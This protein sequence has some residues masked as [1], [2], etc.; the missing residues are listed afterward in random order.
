MNESEI[1]S[2]FLSYGCGP[3]VYCKRVWHRQNRLR[4]GRRQARLC[5]PEAAGGGCSTSLRAGVKLALRCS[6]EGGGG[7][8]G[9]VIWADGTS[10][11]R[12][13]D[14]CRL[15]VSPSLKSSGPTPDTIVVLL[16]HT[17]S[18]LFLEA[19]EEE[20][21]RAGQQDASG[22]RTHSGGRDEDATLFCGERCVDPEWDK[23]HVSLVYPLKTGFEL[24]GTRSF[25]DEMWDQT[26]N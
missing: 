11:L 25:A 12:S 14:E 23:P 9:S 10:S 17:A 22:L 15:S 26:L 19:D 3:T 4:D 21:A 18:S 1:Y 2:C 16:S 5:V 24:V 8:R 20:V 7:S 6:D 13:T